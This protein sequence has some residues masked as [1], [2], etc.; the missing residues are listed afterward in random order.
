MPNRDL[1]NIG[2]LEI[3]HLGSCSYLG[4]VSDLIHRG[5]M[6]TTSWPSYPEKDGVFLFHLSQGS[7]GSR[8]S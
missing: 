6:C 7:G 4:V 3:H 5:Y 8:A 2:G 1:G